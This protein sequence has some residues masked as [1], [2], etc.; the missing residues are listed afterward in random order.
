[1]LILDI[2]DVTLEPHRQTQWKGSSLL[3]QLQ[4][5]CLI[6]CHLLLSIPLTLLYPQKCLYSSKLHEHLP[7]LL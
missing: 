7:E 1:M 2:I 4:S 5:N 6:F 3:F